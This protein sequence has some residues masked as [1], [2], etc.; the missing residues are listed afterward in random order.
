MFQYKL[1]VNSAIQ[2]LAVQWK[3]WQYRGC[4]GTVWEVMAVQKSCQHTSGEV[5]SSDKVL[6]GV[7]TV[8]KKYCHPMEILAVEEIYQ[9]PVQGSL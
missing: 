7:F 2:V 3:S 1:C 8:Q 5:G 6:E 4:V 9:F